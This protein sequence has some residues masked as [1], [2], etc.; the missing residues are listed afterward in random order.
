MNKIYR[1]DIVRLGI[2]MQY[3][4]FKVWEHSAFG[5]VNP[6][7]HMPK[8]KHSRDLAIDVNYNPRVPSSWAE[9]RKFDRLAPELVRRRFGCIW[10]RGPGDH[11]HHLHAETWGSPLQYP[12]RYR[13]KQRITWRKPVAD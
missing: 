11:D 13:L 2:E 1:S 4:G 6:A 9:D 12:G 3:R 10:N 8:S 5:G 7:Y